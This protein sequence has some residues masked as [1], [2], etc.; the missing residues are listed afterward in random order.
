MCKWICRFFRVVRSIFR[1][2]L[3]VFICTLIF[4]SWVVYYGY[5]SGP[6]LEKKSVVV[7]IPKGATVH[8]IGELLADAG[9]VHRDFR[10]A[11]LTKAMRVSARLPAGEFELVS[12]KSPVDVIRQLTT[13]RPLQHIVTIPEGLRATEIAGIFAQGGWCDKSRFVEC[14]TDLPFIQS[15]N[16]KGVKSLEGYLYP[17]TYYLVKGDYSEE[18]LIR[19]MVTRFHKVYG[20]LTAGYEGELNRHEIVTLA[21]IVEKETGNPD[22]RSTIAAVFF[23]RIQ[24]GMRLQSDPTVIYGLENFSGNLTKKDLKTPTPYNTYILPA[25]PAGPICNPGEEAIRAV[26]YPAKKKF[27]YFVSKN[28]GSHYFSK[29]LKEHN[30]AVMIYQKKRGKREDSSHTD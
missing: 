20:Q 25:L 23:N 17:D 10:F 8:Q 30:Q 21:S 4:C 24:N 12:G 27:L 26:L 2:A 11:L 29:S 3:L 7:Q 22:E 1:V 14:V 13:A 6:P 15:L 5:Q 19:M 16:L 28:N 18:K 9:L